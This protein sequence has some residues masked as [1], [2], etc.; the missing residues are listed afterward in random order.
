MEEDKTGVFPCLRGREARRD[1]GKTALCAMPLIWDQP[2]LLLLSWLGGKKEAM[3]RSAQNP[4]CS[5]RS[6][7]RGGFR[8]PPPPVSDFSYYFFLAGEERRALAFS[9]TRQLT[10]HASSCVCVSSLRGG[11]S[12]Q[13]KNNNER[14]GKKII[15]PNPGTLRASL[16]PSGKGL[17]Y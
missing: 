14:E 5:P 17:G 1:K 6:G 13:N 11:F 15:T 12:C 9:C 10:C 4:S 7:R 3:L 16:L 8:T 2:L